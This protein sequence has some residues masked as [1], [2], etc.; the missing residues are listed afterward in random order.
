MKTETCDER[1]ERHYRDR[2]DDIRNLWEA[3][4]E[5]EEDRHSD[6]IGTFW[7]YGLDFSCVPMGTFDDMEAPYFRYQLSWGGPGDEFRFFTGPDLIPYKVEYWFLDWFDGARWPVHGEDLE[8]LQ[9]VFD[10][11]NE[12]GMTAE[13]DSR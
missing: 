12:C 13:Q 3:H 5:G 4:C 10:C 11:F 7:E 6:D 8:L 9:E 1:V 2:I